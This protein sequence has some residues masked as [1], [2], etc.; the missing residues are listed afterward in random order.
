MANLDLG[1]PESSK[2]KNAENMKGQWNDFIFLAL[3]HIAKKDSRDRAIAYKSIEAQVKNSQSFTDQKQFD[4]LEIKL[5][6]AH[7][8]WGND[9]ATEAQ[10]SLLDDSL[11]RMENNFLTDMQLKNI[12]IQTENLLVNS[13]MSVKDKTQAALD[14]LTIGNESMDNLKS[15]LTIRE[16]QRLLNNMEALNNTV[17]L[18]TK[19]YNADKTFGS[20]IED[21]DENSPTYGKWIATEEMDV[22]LETFNDLLS[23]FQFGDLGRAK[24][25]S[26]DMADYKELIEK[27]HIIG[28]IEEEYNT[29]KDNIHLT[30][31]RLASQFLVRMDEEHI[32]DL[33][34]GQRAVYNTL[35]MG[36]G[37][38]TA[39]LALTRKSIPREIKKIESVMFDFLDPNL[40][41]MEKYN[42]AKANDM[43]LQG[44]FKGL[45]NY[46]K[47]KSTQEFNGRK[48]T[49]L[50]LQE[51]RE[52][53]SSIFE[54]TDELSKEEFGLRAYTPGFYPTGEEEFLE[55][56]V[57][58]YVDSIVMLDGLDRRLTMDIRD[59]IE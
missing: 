23:A 29:L 41:I 12:N 55:D 10:L 27:N 51:K 42:D 16:T 4:D 56:F 13:S 58:Q 38:G 31:N 48:Y 11:A 39:H 37:T 53:M 52:L 47:L 15:E 59:R 34:P 5:G 1:N 35:K 24:Y 20:T 54:F 49:E 21:K 33:D 3:D 19:I 9:K 36:T 2:Q 50:D 26:A 25:L 30:S 40:P 14:L 7:Q 32:G 8:M 46:M 22:P 18:G 45:V 57:I 44:G 6:E 28:P 43:Y 17:A